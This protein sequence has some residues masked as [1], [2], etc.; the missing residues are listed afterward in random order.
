L[1]VLRLVLPDLQIDSARA[2]AATAHKTVT[3]RNIAEKSDA[4]VLE[5]DFE[6]ET[7]EVRW[8]RSRGRQILLLKVDLS[9]PNANE[10]TAYE[11]EA[12]ILAAI[13]T[14]P[15]LRL[16][17]AMDIKTDKLSGFWERPQ[18]FQL[19]A[20]SDAFVVYSTHWN[21]GE[22]YN[23]VAVLFMNGDRFETITSIFL[24]NT[25]GCGATVT[26]TPY[27]RVLPNTGR[28]YPS[29]L[30]GVKVKKD[31]DTEQCDH[32]TR[33]YTRYYQSIYYWNRAKAEYDSNSRRFK[34]LDK[35]NR[36]RL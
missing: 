17:D 21:A 31:A 32:Q 16:L 6:I 23:D 7:F 19:N 30:I 36:K 22:S 3:V 2:G 25:Q 28:R 4:T 1:E 29:L 11:G 27:F 35:F 33:G 14:E 26:E 12:S 9:A 20:E 24:F 10:G 18:V 8:I 34:A 15:T 5:G 13:S